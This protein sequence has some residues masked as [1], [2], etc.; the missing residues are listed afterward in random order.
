MQLREI[1]QSATPTHLR[2]SLVSEPH[3][4]LLRAPFWPQYRH[5]FPIS[6]IASIFNQ[7]PLDICR[8]T[9]SQDLQERSIS[10]LQQTCHELVS[11]LAYPSSYERI[12]YLT[13]GR[14][15]PTS[16]QLGLVY[17]PLHG[18]QALNTF[19]QSQSSLQVLQFLQKISLLLILRANN[20]A[21]VD[22]DKLCRPCRKEEPPQSTAS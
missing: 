8:R 16:P 4:P 9:L 2:R 20:L 11:W 14:Y 10:D 1:E 13:H 17:A 3:P 5:S 21:T 6:F 15:L 7:Q 18:L 12:P 19:D 22:S